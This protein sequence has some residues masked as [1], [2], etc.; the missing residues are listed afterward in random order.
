[1]D[2]KTT[3]IPTDVRTGRKAM[4]NPFSEAFPADKEA[5]TFTIP[6]GQDSVEARRLLRQARQAA[7]KVDRTA[8]VVTEEVKG[9]TNFKVWTVARVT[10]K[11]ATDA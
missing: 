2:F 1:M 11:A 3:A 4:D 7:A 10:R 9:K 8:R 6:Q 5:L